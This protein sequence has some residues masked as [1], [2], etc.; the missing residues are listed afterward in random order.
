[1]WDVSPLVITHNQR[2]G[3]SKCSCTHHVRL[4]DPFCGAEGSDE[5]EEKT[6]VNRGAHNYRMIELE[7]GGVKVGGGGWAGR[8]TRARY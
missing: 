8:S 3:N 5:E 2:A 7:G 1:M 4:N 6:D